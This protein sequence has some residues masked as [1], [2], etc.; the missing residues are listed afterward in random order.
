MSRVRLILSLLAILCLAPWLN[1][2]ALGQ[3]GTTTA[4]D[5]SQAAARQTILESARWRQSQRMF[6]EWLSVQQ[7]YT[8]TEVAAL[9]E[10]YRKQIAGMSPR[11]LERFLK[12]MEDRLKV[13]LS[14]Q[15]KEAR[16][17]LSQVLTVARDPAAHLGREIPDVRSMTA[18]Q[19][20]Q[21]LQW[22]EQ[23][24]ESSRQS[25]AAFDRGR[26]MKVETAQEMHLA[27]RQSQEHAR[28]LRAEAGRPRV[29]RSV[30]APR[31]NNQPG[32]DPRFETRAPAY[33]VGPWGTP[34]RWDPFNNR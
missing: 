22:V 15:A 27:N 31:P 7:I 4:D 13:L 30:Y 29:Y 26:S 33:R 12:D 5:A 8:P 10:E 1:G 3:G 23:R 17:W 14:P 16:R 6:D 2:S 32:P 21:E 34:I 28:D 20:R 24:R 9:R 19:I 11:E 18:N 25:Q